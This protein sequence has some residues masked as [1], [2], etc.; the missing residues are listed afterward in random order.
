MQYYMYDMDLMELDLAAQNL[1]YTDRNIWD[2]TRLLGLFTLMPHTK[3]RLKTKDIFSLPWDQE[4][5]KLTE[6][7]KDEF[8]IM[9]HKMQKLEK[10]FNNITNHET[11]NQEEKN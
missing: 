3:K 6:E 10:K 4:S 7:N 8:E 1:Q 9:L 5:E 11:D 2:S